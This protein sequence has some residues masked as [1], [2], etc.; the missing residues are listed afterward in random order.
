MF[1]ALKTKLDNFSMTGA[2][3]LANNKRNLN[4]DG[5]LW[6]FAGISSFLKAEYFEHTN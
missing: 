6:Y 2:F 5:C 4:W 1:K 3:V